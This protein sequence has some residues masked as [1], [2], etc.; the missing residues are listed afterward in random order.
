[1]SIKL[2]PGHI[3]HHHLTVRKH[4]YYPAIINNFI[5]IIIPTIINN[6]IIIKIPTTINNLSKRER[7][8]ILKEV[9]LHQYR[10][11]MIRE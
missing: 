10:D 1:M 11:C 4:S 3:S 8:G 2:L 6:L 7:G 9:N 5:I